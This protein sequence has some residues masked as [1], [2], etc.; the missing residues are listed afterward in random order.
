[1]DRVVINGFTDPYCLVQVFNNYFNP[2]GDESLSLISISEIG[3]N[4]IFASE[5]LL[6]PGL[7][8]LIIRAVGPNGGVKEEIRQIQRKE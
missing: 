5:V 2:D 7:N 4:G 1:M 3:P 8:E 6:K